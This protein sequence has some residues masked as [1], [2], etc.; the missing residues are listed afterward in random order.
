MVRRSPPGGPWQAADRGAARALREA[1]FAAGLS[2]AIV[3]RDG[4]TAVTAT[5]LAD[6]AAGTPVG[7]DTL[8]EIGSISKGFCCALLLAARDHG[9]VDLDGPVADV[10]PWFEVP[11][12][13][14]PITPR[15]LMSHTG[16]IVMGTEF[17][18]DAAFEVWSLRYTE[19]GSEPGTWFHYSNVGYK[20]LGL[21][22]EAVH[23]R[24]Y[25]RILREDLLEPLG[26]T[27]TEPAITH[28]V[29]RRLAVGYEP[30]YDDRPPRRADGLAPATWL[31]TATADG[32]VA[33]TAGDMTLWLRFLMD[34]GVAAS[35]ERLLAAAS[36]AEML[37]PAISSEEELPGSGY[38][39]GMWSVERDG[40]R[41]IGHTGGMV[42]YHAAVACDLDEGVGAVVLANGWGPWRETT[43]HAL[44]VVRAERAGQTP[45]EFEPPSPEPPAPEPSDPGDPPAGLAPFVGHYRCH[46]PWMTD[47]RVDVRGGE[48][49]LGFPSGDVWDA[50]LPLVPLRDGVFRVGADPRSPE[51]LAF[52][53]VIDGV[54]VRAVYS[55]C[56]FYRTFT[57]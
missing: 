54:A 55:N 3:E 26:M 31:E 21:V 40:H 53:T 19:T 8:F 9:M 52:D 28:E 29:R 16:G 36:V 33:S 30:F 2:L 49:R 15:H 18:G 22:L 45:P 1:S 20:A 57:P 48:L 25:H 17:S 34:E 35:G 12:R 56:A 38:G 46:N 39:L 24:P 50:E 47:L 23:G 43:F 27:S 13:F 42:G 7:P 51:R 4:P 5:G 32:N 11:S 10:L 14:G 44:A 41:F 37:A 6:L